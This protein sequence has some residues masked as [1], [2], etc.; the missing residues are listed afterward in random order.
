LLKPKWKV[1]V[2]AMIMRC[3]RLELISEDRATYLWKQISRQHWRKS[4]PYDDEIAK[5]ETV[6]LSQAI[7]LLI[8]EGHCSRNEIADDL[9]LATD[10]IEQ[11]CG[12]EQGFFRHDDNIVEIDFLRKS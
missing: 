7:K 6:V 9:A 2:Q 1:S 3:E 4:E 11:V 8:K 12:L 5:E 10:F